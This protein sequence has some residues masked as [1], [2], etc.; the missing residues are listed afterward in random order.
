MSE[1]TLEDPVMEF[2]HGPLDGKVVP[3][4]WSRCALSCSRTHWPRWVMPIGTTSYLRRS[5]ARRTL[6]A[7]MH[8]MAC[9]LLRPPKMTA[10]R[11]RPMAQR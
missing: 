1:S 9:S 3:M 4:T 11:R 7:E 6:P 8:E 10:T 5:M 2:I